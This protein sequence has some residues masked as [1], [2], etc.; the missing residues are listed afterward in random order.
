MPKGWTLVRLAMEWKI[1]W[2]HL[3]FTFQS[4]TRAGEMNEAL[5]VILVNQMKRI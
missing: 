1:Y 5:Q 4:Y 3:S 2:I